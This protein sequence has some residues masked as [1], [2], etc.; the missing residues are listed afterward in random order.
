MRP[1]K[2]LSIMS[3]K[4]TF[5]K[6]KVPETKMNYV[7]MLQESSPT[8]LGAILT[9]QLKHAA[10]G[11]PQNGSSKL[12]LKH[13]HTGLLGNFNSTIPRSTFCTSVLTALLKMH[14]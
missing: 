4:Y 10:L 2:G 14:F 13:T 12:F 3:E 7:L 9:N 6:I 1:N 5:A 11:K 8:A